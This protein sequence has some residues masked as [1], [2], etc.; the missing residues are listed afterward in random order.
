MTSGNL[1]SMHQTRNVELAAVESGLLT[2]A[3]C[4]LVAIKTRLRRGVV[5][6]LC[7]TQSMICNNVNYI[8]LSSDT[9]GCTSCNR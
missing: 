1:V 9:P 4:L 8:A 6:V 7:S 3:G 2:V 5:V